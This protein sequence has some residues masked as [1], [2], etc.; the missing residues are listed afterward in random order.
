MW[1]VGV[2]IVIALGAYLIMAKS[3][4]DNSEMANN[5]QSNSEVK[6]S[7]SNTAPA[8]SVQHTDTSLKA[9][10]ASGTSQKC[11]YSD[12]GSEGVFY[13]SGG[14]SRGDFTTTVS[15]KT[16]ASH[17]IS[18]GKTSYIWM[19]G[20]PQGYKMS[21]EVNASTNQQA[22][23]TA[24]SAQQGVDVNKTMNYDCQAWSADNSMFNLPS[25]IEF[26]DFAAM[27]KGSMKANY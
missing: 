19:D 13:L 12:S 24:A 1:A 3:K 5:A 18:D 20:Q 27:M 23:S 26:V 10:L 17:M 16:T 6:N 8:N 25:G 9:L 2:V 11:S 15:G 21:L 22:N 14:K 4:T 7:Q